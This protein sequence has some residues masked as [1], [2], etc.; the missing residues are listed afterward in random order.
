MNY[1]VRRQGQDLGFFPLEELVKGRE[2]GRFTG[3]EYVQAEGTTDWQPLDLVLKQ[4]YRTTP[5]PLPPIAARRGPNPALIWIGIGGGVVLCLLFVVGMGFMASR[6]Q[7][8]LSSPGGISAPS[9]LSEPNPSAVATAGKAIVWDH[10]TQTFT[11]EQKRERAFRLRLWVD[12]Y[13]KHGTRN[14]K[15]DAEADLFLRTYIARNYGGQFGQR[16]KLYGSIGIDRG[17]GP[18]SE[19]V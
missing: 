11:D 7:R 13:E 2:T 18:G 19:P 3:T 15:C 6:F 16:Y 17:G 1:H 10:N 8:N 4:G 12:G 5:P 14:P 9:G